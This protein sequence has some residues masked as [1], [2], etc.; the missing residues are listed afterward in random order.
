METVVEDVAELVEEEV[1]PDVP[2]TPQ[3]GNDLCGPNGC[4]GQCGSCDEGESCY[5]GQCVVL[6]GECDDGNNVDWDGCTEG[7]LSE[8][9][10]NG[11]TKDDQRQPAVAAS[12]ESFV[13]VW[14]SCPW[15]EWEGPSTD[16]DNWG[17]GIFARR[18]MADD[19][20]M[21]DEYQVNETIQY[22]QLAPDVAALGDNLVMSWLSYAGEDLQIQLRVF[23]DSGAPLSGEIAG[24]AKDHLQQWRPV[25]A[26]AG[27]DQI[28]VAWLGIRELGGI[29]IMGQYFHWDQDTTSLASVGDVFEL[30]QQSTVE[31]MW[32]RVSTLPTGTFVAAWGAAVSGDP[33]VE[34]FGQFVDYP[35]GPLGGEFVLNPAL[36]NEGA[37]GF[38]D[39]AAAGGD[40]DFIAVYED[41]SVHMV[42]ESGLSGR[43]FSSDGTPKGAAKPLVISGPAVSYPVVAPISNGNHFVAWGT[44]HD[45]DD[46]PWLDVIRVMDLEADLS[47]NVTTTANLHVAG[48]QKFVRVAVNPN[49]NHRMVVWESCPWDQYNES[50]DL[51]GQDGDGC[52]IFARIYD[53]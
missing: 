7:H 39:V 53:N 6:T 29:G 38:P 42:G 27:D 2:C 4:G 49:T 5:F 23:S 3:C 20:V 37:Q 22:N 30:K 8:F 26:T 11:A 10:V 44:H 52:G 36:G 21:E 25:L 41:N 34:A 1:A 47:K 13:A 16:H 43:L 18:I 31:T 51:P 24:N 9:R 46:S 35:N 19:K 40:G 45:A 28:L 15:D 50:L 48:Y 12:G 33:Y 14:Q 17:C 32:P